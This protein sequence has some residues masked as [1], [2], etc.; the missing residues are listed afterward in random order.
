[1]LHRQAAA[2]AA[3]MSVDYSAGPEALLKQFSGKQGGAVEIGIKKGEIN[4]EKE[5]ADAELAAAK[6]GTEKKEAAAKIEAAEAKLKA[7]T[8][9]EALATD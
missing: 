6:T 1:M 4:K 5:A 8:E 2:K 3:E 9:A 7:L